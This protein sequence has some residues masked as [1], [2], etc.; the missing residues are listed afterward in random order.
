[1]KNMKT[2]AFIA[3]FYLDPVL[4]SAT[5]TVHNKSSRIFIGAFYMSSTCQQIKNFKFMAF[6][7]RNITVK[8]RL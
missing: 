7:P 2:G 4:G 8:N 3:I 6:M 1:M 5:R